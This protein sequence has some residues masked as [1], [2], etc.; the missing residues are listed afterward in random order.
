MSDGLR[1][2]AP[3]RRA[4]LAGTASLATSVALGSGVGAV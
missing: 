1:T 2:P 4:F 3:S